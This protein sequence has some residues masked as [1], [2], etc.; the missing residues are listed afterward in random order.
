[1]SFNSFKNL[2]LLH[3]N[4]IKCLNQIRLKHINHPGHKKKPL[5]NPYI[6]TL[7]DRYLDE[8]NYPPVKP[9]F[10]PGE[11]PDSYD[12]KLAWLYF[13]EGEKFSSLKTIQERLSVLAYL[14]VQQ[15]L[16]DIKIN[17]TRYY[18]IYNISACLKSPRTLEFSQ[19]ITK[20]HLIDGG[21]KDES[22]EKTVEEINKDLFDKIKHGVKESIL[23]NANKVNQ[24]NEQYEAP[25]HQDA[26]RPK[27]LEREKNEGKAI[28]SSNS[29]IKDILDRITS[30]LSIESSG[31]YLLNAQYAT[32]V[33]IKAYWKRCGYEEQKPRG[34]TNPDSDVI[35]FQFDDIAAYQIKTDKPLRPIFRLDQDECTKENVIST[36]SFNPST[37]KVFADHT[38]P[39]QVPGH[40]YGD[41]RE[42]NYLTV[43]NTTKTMSYF[44]NK[45]AQNINENE[46]IKSI[47]C[48][49]GH[50]E[51]TSQAYYLGFSMWKD[52]TYPLVAQQI[53]T[54][55][56]N[57]SFSNY[58][59]NTL[60]L[61]NKA[62]KLNNLSFVTP[63]ESL[64]E[65]NE[66]KTDFKNFNDNLLKKILKMFSNKQVEKEEDLC[67]G[68]SELDYMIGGS[69]LRPY[70]S[71]Q[72]FEEQLS[73][74]HKLFAISLY[75]LVKYDKPTDYL[76]L[77]DETKPVSYRPKFSK[78]Y[79][80]YTYD[81]R[82][83]VLD[84]YPRDYY[85]LKLIE[86]M[87][88]RKAPKQTEKF[89]DLKNSVY[90]W[91]NVP[92]SHTNNI[93]R[94]INLPKY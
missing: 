47:A 77:R 69:R 54:D 75:E 60:R 61:W 72:N 45:Y 82:D 35:R 90:E 42:F 24:L 41:N 21:S 17:R 32:D 94:N 74:R 16:D 27:V 70:L 84:Y 40:W 44:K 13:D 14:N 38:L 39:M 55:G 67:K 4:F 34:A 28:L 3:H 19:Y 92:P 73:I 36:C 81:F 11:W 23:I 51:L 85:G 46:I 78:L 52:V 65:L 56:K 58:Q 76:N 30:I 86:R 50:A 59:L 7:P 91:A 9:K 49:F 93:P 71:I 31:S 63:T 83:I 37:Y 33:S 25:I 10:P 66:E 26:Y 80:K 48:L 43:Y 87:I 68:Y 20:T 8:P 79:D 22:V 89:W 88:L 53:F 64:F 62:T 5:T 2:C 29:L 6:R 57:Y 15:T 18:P 12:P 1:M